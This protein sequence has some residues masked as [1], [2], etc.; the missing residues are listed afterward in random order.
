MKSFRLRRCRTSGKPS[1]ALADR[2]EIT[3]PR[4]EAMVIADATAFVQS[5][6]RWPLTWRGVYLS[7][8]V[9]MTV[10]HTPGTQAK[11]HPPLST[12]DVAHRG[13]A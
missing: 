12:E 10:W 4:L 9:S 6:M 13:E 7:G 8:N 3:H 1:F 2:V 5:E 11:S